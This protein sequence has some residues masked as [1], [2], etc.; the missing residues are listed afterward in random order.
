MHVAF[1]DA[2]G[3]HYALR[4]LIGVALAQFIFHYLRDTNPLW[5]IISVVMVSEPEVSAAMKAFTSRLTTTLIG[6]VVAVAMVAAAGP[7]HWIIPVAAAISALIVYYLIKVPISWK[8]APLT[9]ALVLTM[10]VLEETREAGIMFALARGGEV[11]AGGLIAV[12]VSWAVDLVWPVHP[13]HAAEK[14]HA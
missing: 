3:L 4:I 12:I 2:G 9:A 10:A 1:K 5:A 14:P 11:L 7:M 13:H 8:V 6:C